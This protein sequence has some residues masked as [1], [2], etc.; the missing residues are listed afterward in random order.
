M[1]VLRGIFH[2][3]FRVFH[4]NYTISY[5]KQCVATRENNDEETNRC[6]S[7]Y[8]MPSES[9]KCRRVLQIWKHLNAVGEGY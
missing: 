6:A 8:K 5:G 7:F 9:E 2:K 3:N 1:Q 4:S